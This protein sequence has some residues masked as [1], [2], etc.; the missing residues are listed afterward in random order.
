[1]HVVPGTGQAKRQPQKRRFANDIEPKSTG[2]RSA[3]ALERIRRSCVDFPSQLNSTV[4]SQWLELTVGWE[5]CTR[6]SARDDCVCALQTS[7]RSLLS[8]EAAKVPDD[9]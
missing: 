9:W 7:V 2:C 4:R 6:S 8:D 1:M 3:D 5:P